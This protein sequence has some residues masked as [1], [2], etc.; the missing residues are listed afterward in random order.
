VEDERAGGSG[1]WRPLELGSAVYRHTRRIPFHPE[2][3]RAV[4]PAIAAAITAHACD[5]A[6]ANAERAT[7]SMQPTTCNRELETLTVATCVQHCMPCCTLQIVC[8]KLQRRTRRGAPMAAKSEAD[9][10]PATPSG[11]HDVVHEAVRRCAPTCTTVAVRVHSSYNT[12]EPCHATPRR[13]C[14]RQLKGCTP[15]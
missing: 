7:R 2:A 8:C 5:R 9:A 6:T 4:W 15:S 12:F 11:C 3:S 10:I 1:R 13:R 14:A